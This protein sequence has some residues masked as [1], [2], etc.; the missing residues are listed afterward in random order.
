MQ[1]CEPA[2]A[3]YTLPADPRAQVYHFSDPV[4]EVG[5][6]YYYVILSVNRIG[7]SEWVAMSKPAGGQAFDISMPAAPEWISLERDVASGAPAIK[8]KWRVQEPV[9]VIVTRRVAGTGFFQPASGWIAAAAGVKVGDS[10]DY[11]FEDRAEAV[12]WPCEY[13]VT[14]R[15]RMGPKI[16]GPV[17]NQV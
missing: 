15:R 2:N 12:Q 11:V 17:S 3:L 1:L 13:R 6:A 7:T 4:P 10:Y 14:A 8:L 9:D 16:T 5:R